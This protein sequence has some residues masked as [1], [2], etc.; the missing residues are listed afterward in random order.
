MTNIGWF[1]RMEVG[2]NE[3]NETHGTNYVYRGSA[4]G[5]RP[6]RRR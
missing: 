5:R 6:G 4:E 1:Q 3:Y 2:V